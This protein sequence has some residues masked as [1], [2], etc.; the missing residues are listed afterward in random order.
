MFQGQ[1]RAGAEPGWQACEGLLLLLRD[2]IVA[3][4]EHALEQA[5]ATAIQ[6]ESLVV[7]A[8]HGDAGVRAAVLRAAAALQRRRAAALSPLCGLLLA[9]QVAAPPAS[10]ALAAACAALLT[11]R[12]VPLED[13][14]D[15]SAC[16]IHYDTY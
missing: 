14:L 11:A 9:N 4:P 5:V 1:V 15:V 7:L 3:L 16:F 8:N 10:W 13:Q 12:D 6:A 2:A